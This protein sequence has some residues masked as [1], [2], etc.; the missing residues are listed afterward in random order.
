[1]FMMS[2]DAKEEK[3]M[4]MNDCVYHS[5]NG[6]KVLGGKAWAQKDGHFC[7]KGPSSGTKMALQVP[8]RKI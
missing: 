1:M 7:Q 2:D 5:G 8:E 3:M 4:I 6:K